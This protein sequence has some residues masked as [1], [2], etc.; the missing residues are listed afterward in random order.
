M[1]AGALALSIGPLIVFVG[2]IVGAELAT[3]PSLSTLPVAAMIVGTACSVVPMT[4]LMAKYNRK[5][6]FIGGSVYGALISM[7]AAAMVAHGSFWGFTFSAFGLGVC[8]AIV[9]QFRFAAME[10]VPQK[11]ASSAASMVLIG[12]LIAAFVGPEIAHIGRDLSEEKFSGSF[13]LL[14]LVQLVAACIL[15]LYTDQ[16]KTEIASAQT[17]ARSLRKIARQKIFWV[18]VLAGSIGYAVMSYVM[19]ATPVSMHHLNSH[20]LLDTK[21]VIQSHILAMYL[22]SF[23]SGYLIDRFGPR[24]MILHRASGLCNLH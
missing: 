9:A 2:G 3:A 5:R 14:A 21:W 11:Q 13:V 19:T 22:P 1:L 17:N 12:G 10:C 4:R 24:K 7:M 8:L 15:L 6:I 23:F 16:K 18:A 20:S